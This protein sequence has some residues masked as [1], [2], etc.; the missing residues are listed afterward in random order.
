MYK[1]DSDKPNSKIELVCQNLDKEIDTLCEHIKEQE[2]I[3]NKFQIDANAKLKINDK[4]GEK[5]C[6]GY[7]DC[8]E[9]EWAKQVVGWTIS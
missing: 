4:N 8:E 6:V 1:N 2:K 9:P 7:V 5:T 3:A